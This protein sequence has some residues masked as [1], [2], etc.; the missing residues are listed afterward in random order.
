MARRDPIIR[1]SEISQYS[2][3]A[4]AW[5]L[6]RVRGYQSTNLRDMQRG[7]RE[8][9]AHGRAVRNAHRLRR[10]AVVLLVLAVILLAAWFILGG[11]S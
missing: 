2:F 4:H 10:L 11:G 9:R 7:S 5:W 6:G 8:H 3:C 1:A